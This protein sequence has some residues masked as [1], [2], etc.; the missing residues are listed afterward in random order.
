MDKVSP[1]K[2]GQGDLFHFVVSFETVGKNGQLR[3]GAR[4]VEALSI[5]LARELAEASLVREGVK[6][7]RIKSVRR[8]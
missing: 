2:T 6:P 7:Y 4:V 3:S 1:V 8:F 5:E